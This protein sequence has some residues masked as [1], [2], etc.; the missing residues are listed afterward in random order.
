VDDY[1][2]RNQNQIYQTVETVG[3]KLVRVEK[4][5]Q[6]A[7]QF[8][9]PLFGTHILAMSKRIMAEVMCL[10]EKIGVRMFYTDTDSI[11]LLKDDLPK[12]EKAFK[13]TYDR[14]LVGDGLGAFH[15]DFNATFNKKEKVKYA[16][17]SIFVAK[18]IYIDKLLLANGEFDVM[19]KIKG[20]SNDALYDACGIDYNTP[21][22]EAIE[23]LMNLYKRLYDGEKIAFN[24]ASSRPQFDFQDSFQVKNKYEMIRNVCV[25]NQK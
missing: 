9:N 8:S 10:A 17:E 12:L 16:V 23:K 25:P 21:K 7:N 18:K 22:E 24:L 11:H 2:I 15:T 20:I 4:Y 3:E 14:D 6:I 1:I 13:E 5:K 19:A